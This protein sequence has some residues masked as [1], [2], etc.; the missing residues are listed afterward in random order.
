MTDKKS[1]G[2]S[3]ALQ[4]GDIAAELALARARAGLSHSDLHRIT[5]ISRSVIFGYE[6]GRTKPGAREIRLLCD[7]LKVSPNR[8]I[9][10]SDE[11]QFNDDP[12][13]FYEVGLD[14][15]SSGQLALASLM[16][17]LTNEERLALVTL[18]RAIL[19]GRHGKQ[20]LDQAASVA[21]SLA[22]IVKAVDTQNETRVFSRE[23]LEELKLVLE[24]HIANTPP[25]QK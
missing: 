12:S 19:I 24:E 14:K 23:E 7:A 16:T 10:G 6:N 9:Y 1:P 22:D 20:V 4:L 15:S 5:G 18:T 13:P 11:S 2:D 25:S 3:P 17:M 21:L 8:L